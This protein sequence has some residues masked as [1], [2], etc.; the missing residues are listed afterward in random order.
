[1]LTLTYLRATTMPYQPGDRLKLENAFK[2]IWHTCFRVVQ[3]DY[4]TLTAKQLTLQEKI[5]FYLLAPGACSGALFIKY[6]SSNTT[7]TRT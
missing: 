1:M 5:A 2:P 7:V 4:Y 6:S 3:G